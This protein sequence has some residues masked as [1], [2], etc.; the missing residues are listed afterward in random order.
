MQN[1]AVKG[2]VVF[3]KGCRFDHKETNKIS[4]A[5]F[6]FSV[7]STVFLRSGQTHQKL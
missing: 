5:I 2:M 7:I 1:L 3:R 4:L 6:L